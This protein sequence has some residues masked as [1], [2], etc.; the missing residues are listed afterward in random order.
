MSDNLTDSAFFAAHPTRNYRIRFATQQEIADCKRDGTI[1]PAADEPGKFIFSI[2]PRDDTVTFLVV[3]PL[4]SGE[5][6]EDQCRMLWMA[7]LARNWLRV[8]A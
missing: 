7:A 1:F 4:R 3:M 8:F 5:P 2:V 6:S